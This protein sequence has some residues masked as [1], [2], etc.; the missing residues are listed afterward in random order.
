MSIEFK[1]AWGGPQVKRETKGGREGWRLRCFVEPCSN[2]R[3]S[4]TNSAYSVN[5]A[6]AKNAVRIYNNSL[7]HSPGQPG[8]GCF[9]FE[10]KENGEYTKHDPE[11][12]V[13]ND[14]ADEFQGTLT[15]QNG[16][17]CLARDK[18]KCVGDTAEGPSKKPLASSASAHPPPPRQPSARENSP[19]AG[20]PRGGQS[21]PE[22]VT[23]HHITPGL[24][25]N[26]HKGYWLNPALNPKKLVKHREGAKENSDYED[27]IDWLGQG[28]PTST[29]SRF[30]S[31]LHL[32]KNRWDWEG[33]VTCEKMEL[34]AA[35]E[36]GGDILGE[37]EPSVGSEPT[38]LL[39]LFP[40][41]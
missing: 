5:E 10:K 4:A 15:L 29:T 26:F 24:Y 7:K 18:S 30:P 27:Y 2:Q 39:F 11:E 22:W 40:P 35:G 3:K 17:L 31:S 14:K 23:K 16:G 6:D 34:P 8:H 36:L 21:L 1:D 33:E 32:L 13:I 9:L 20:I 37:D 28:M 38:K 12:I 41:P 25:A 19:R